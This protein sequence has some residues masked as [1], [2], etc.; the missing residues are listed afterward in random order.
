MAK[1][2]YAELVGYYIKQGYT[3]KEAVKKA[4]AEYRQQ[5]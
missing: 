1:K 5:K 4:K 3:F 2:T